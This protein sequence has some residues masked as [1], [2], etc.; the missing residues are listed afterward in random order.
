MRVIP[1]LGDHFYTLDKILDYSFIPS[2]TGGHVCSD[3]ER[4]LFYYFYGLHS[5]K[6]PEINFFLTCH[7]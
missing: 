1:G 4:S 3:E 7:E 2:I 6:T 5:R